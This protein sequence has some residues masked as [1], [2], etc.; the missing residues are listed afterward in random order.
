MAA[1]PVQRYLA[2]FLGTFGL[3]LFGIGTALFSTNFVGVD[4]LVA[5]AFAFGLVVLVGA[6]A[7]GD[8][9]GAH[10]N[11]AV[12]ISMAV[13]GKMQ[14]RDVV[15]YIAAQLLGGLLAVE[16]LLGIV[17]GAPPSL[18]QIAQTNALTSQCF[19]TAGAACP[20]NGTLAAV[21]L[22]EV[23]L[24][25]FFVLVIHLVTREGSS[26]RPLAPIA[27]GFA[28][29]LTQFVAIPIDGASINPVRS[30]AP[31]IVSLVWPSARWAINEVW[32]FIL[33][34]TLGGLL[35]AAVERVL[36]PTK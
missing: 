32:V 35:T 10:F 36:R 34:P 31:A 4:R 17:E 23:V 22:L 19:N 8:I 7:F 33:A 25:F 6:F 21:F 2:E 18:L 9:S 13:S 12:T 29:L 15:P 14:R 24:T 5:I 26:A 28:L 20:S 11:P 1:Q 27:I 3:L 16:I 30:L